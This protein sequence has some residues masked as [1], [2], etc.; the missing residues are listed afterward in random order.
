MN[1]HKKQ[2]VSQRIP[3][4]SFKSEPPDTLTRETLPAGR[5]FNLKNFL[6]AG[7]KWPRNKEKSEPG[8][9]TDEPGHRYKGSFLSEKVNSRTCDFSDRTTQNQFFGRENVWVKVRFF[10]HNIVETIFRFMETVVL[11]DSPQELALAVE[12]FDYQPVT[13]ENNALSVKSGFSRIKRSLLQP[14]KARVGERLTEKITSIAARYRSLE[15]NS[16]P[17][18]V[19]QATFSVANYRFRAKRAGV[20][21]GFS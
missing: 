11:L 9:P 13:T 19:N 21:F 15:N 14:A 2:L 5:E 10:F 17:L 7:F 6:S 16:I 4:N 18:G 1:G 8:V 20:T 12:T 3:A